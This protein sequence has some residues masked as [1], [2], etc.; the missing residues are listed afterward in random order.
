MRRINQDWNWIFPILVLVAFSACSPLPYLE[1]N[2]RLPLR[3]E[4][5]R[6]QRVSLDVE[7]ARPVK[8]MMGSG[9]RD[10]FGNFSGNV[11]LAV[12]RG[13]EESGV[14]VGLYEPPSLFKEAF[15]KRLENAGAEVLLG[16]EKGVPD[17]KVIIQRL[18]LDLVD[19][20]WIVQMAYEAR[21]SKDGKVLAR[22]IVSGEG[23]R[24]KLMGRDQAETV[25]GDVFTDLV[26]RVDLDKLFREA[27]L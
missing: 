11:S 22:Q 5:L 7:D 24:M 6:G 3:S 10:D 18:M 4:S 2:Y 14:R 16:K 8:D 17:L 12:A 15:R 21:L 1:V 20:R 23:E 19:R 27:G 25:L 13:S 26:N 9:A